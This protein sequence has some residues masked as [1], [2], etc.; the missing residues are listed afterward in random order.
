[1]EAEHTARDAT[2][3]EHP[4]DLLI[5]LCVVATAITPPLL[6]NVAHE[7]FSAPHE[8]VDAGVHSQPQ[9]LLQGDKVFGTPSSVHEQLAAE[10]V[11][12]IFAPVLFA[13]EASST[14]YSREA[15]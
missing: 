5:G 12:V 13:P 15:L 4:Q 2:R 11:T 7:Q 10:Q 9:S 8:A 1:L 6:S 3:Q 14:T